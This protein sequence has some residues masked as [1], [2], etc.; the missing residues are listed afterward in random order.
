M[1]SDIQGLKAVDRPELR[2]H[3]NVIVFSSQGARPAQDKMAKGD[4][5]GDTYFVCWDPEM[6]Q[7]LGPD[8]FVEP[9]DQIVPPGCSKPANNE[10]DKTIA[11]FLT[12]YYSEDFIGQVNNLH[13]AYCD[14]YGQHGPHTKEALEIAQFCR[15]AINFGKHGK[16]YVS[17]EDLE[18][19]YC[20]IK[21]TYPDFM[22]KTDK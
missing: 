2:D 12:W 4:L 19:Y 9:L 5:D 3:F 15:T 13:L 14:R 17:Y 18:E 16:D 10:L 1:P 8:K 11:S 22:E 20:K 21:N 6:M 7:H